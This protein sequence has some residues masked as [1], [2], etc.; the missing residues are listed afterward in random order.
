[1]TPSSCMQRLAAT[2]LLGLSVGGAM[3]APGTFNVFSDLPMFGIYVSTP[4]AYT[5]PP[6]VVMQ[7]NGTRF[8]TQLTSAQR[9]LIGS[10]LKARV[11]YHAQCDNYDRL[12]AMFLIVKPVG[13][14]LSDG[15]PITEVARWITP[16]SNYWNGV[17][18]TYTFPDADLSA[19]A[20]LMRN[21]N[22]DVWVGI[23]GGSNPYTG[24]PCT[25]RDVTPEFRAVGFR[26][27]LDL[28][29]TRG[30]PKLKSTAAM[31]VPFGDYTAVPVAGAARLAQASAGTA[32]VI[33]SGHGAANGG[34]EYKHTNDTLTLNG[35]VVGSFSTMVDCKRYR[36]YSPDGNP[37][38]FLNNKT[39]NPR[40]WCPGALVA[41]RAFK[42]SLLP[43]NTVSLGMGDARV[44]EGSYYRT[45]ITLLPH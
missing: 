7:R 28:A 21:P 42:V 2:A 9:A 20:G 38:I 36:Q 25:N 19:F 3:A 18:A 13:V 8:V 45:S 27:S 35:N 14:P 15:D 24:D 34:D 32:V 44:P 22:L 33:V 16:F 10:D 29:S 40:N 30:T 17:K 4:P 37:F 39:S 43:E 5:P 6:G 41:A 12:G 23:D 31:P 1:M 26:Y 11:T